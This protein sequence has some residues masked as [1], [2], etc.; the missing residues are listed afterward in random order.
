MRKQAVGFW[1]HIY[2]REGPAWGPDLREFPIEPGALARIVCSYALPFLRHSLDV[3][4]NE[5][6]LPRPGQLGREE[7]LA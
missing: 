4:H 1:E 7:G 5:P 6:P 3:A 2:G